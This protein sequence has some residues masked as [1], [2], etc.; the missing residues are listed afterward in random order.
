M[1]KRP[2]GKAAKALRAARKHAPVSFVGRVVGGKVRIENKKGLR[3]HAKKMADKDV[4]FVA[5]NAPFK[6]RALVDSA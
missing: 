2:T 1:A 4:W 6:T 5:L 3:A